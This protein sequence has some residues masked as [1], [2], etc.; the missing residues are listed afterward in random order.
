MEV[1]C[2][3]KVTEPHDECI[4]VFRVRPHYVGPF[5]C[6][7]HQP[8]GGGCLQCQSNCSAD[9]IGE[10]CGRGGN[11]RWWWECDGICYLLGWQH[12]RW[13]LSPCAHCFVKTLSDPL[14][15]FVVVARHWFN[16][17]AKYACIFLLFCITVSRSNQ[18]ISHK[19]PCILVG[20]HCWVIDMQHDDFETLVR[21]LPFFMKL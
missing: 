15:D 10:A 6:I 12:C 3:D 19:V 14:S 4:L 7:W 8:C 20:S 16:V 18:P 11:M 17:D 21:H 13:T 9:V 5:C 2:S 1:A